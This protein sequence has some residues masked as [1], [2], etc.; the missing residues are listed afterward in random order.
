MSIHTEDNMLE[1]TLVV[2]SAGGS[3]YA[4][5]IG[6]VAEVLRMVAVR[7]LPDS[8][9]WQAGA[10]NLRGTVIP[11]IDL[12]ARL[13]VDAVIGLDTPILIVGKG[14]EQLGL[15]VDSVEDLLS[16]T[17][18]QT[19]SPQQLGQVSDLVIAAVKDGSRLILQ[20]DPKKLRD[21]V[22]PAA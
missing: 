1:S 9:H 19:S 15:I 16:V 2:F 6:D 21:G 18:E 14:S 10:V 7:P 17:P 11:V 12:R 4:L 20:L 22:V 5:R 13:G 8:P 3:D